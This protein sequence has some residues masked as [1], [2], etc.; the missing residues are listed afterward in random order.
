MRRLHYKNQIIFFD[1]YNNH[2]DE[3]TLIHI[4]HRN[5]QPFSKKSGDSGNDHSNDDESNAKPESLYNDAKVSWML[6]YGT[7][8]RLPH[9]MISTLLE[10]AYTFMVFTRNIIRDRSVNTKLLTLSPTKLITNT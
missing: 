10:T 8:K 3:I 2:Y 6:K 1:G 4:E 7:T 9:H 5:I